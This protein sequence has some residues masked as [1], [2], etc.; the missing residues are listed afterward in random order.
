[1]DGSVEQT[2]KTVM[3]EDESAEI[4]SL[5]SNYDFDDPQVYWVEKNF[6]ET[7][8]QYKINENTVK[9]IFTNLTNITAVSG[10]RNKIYY[11]RVGENC[12]IHVQTLSDQNKMEL[13][14]NNTLSIT[15]MAIYNPDIEKVIMIMLFA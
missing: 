10:Y 4:K 6:G 7:V 9:K 11:A 12:T 13:Y 1:M 14:R 15:S 2:I 8:I 3:I 5:T